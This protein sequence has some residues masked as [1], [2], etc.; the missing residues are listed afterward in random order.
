MVK[1]IS[2]PHAAWKPKLNEKERESSW[3]KAA[4]KNKSLKQHANARMRFTRNANEHEAEAKNGVGLTTKDIAVLQNKQYRLSKQ[5]AHCHA[6]RGKQENRAKNKANNRA[7]SEKPG[8]RTKQNTKQKA[9]AKAKADSLQAE[10]AA[11]YKAN[12]TGRTTDFGLGDET[13]AD[14]LKELVHGIM[15]S[16]AGVFQFEGE[17]TTRNWIRDHGEKSREEILS[18][19]EWAAYFL[20]TK[21]KI[22]PGKEIK[23]PET[24][25][26]MCNYVRN[27]L[28]RIDTFDNGNQRDFRRFTGKEAKTVVLTYLLAK[29]VSGYD[30]TS[31]EGSLQRYIEKEMGM[32]HGFCLRKKAGAGP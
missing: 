2:K 14:E 18:S 31:L 24:M 30:A 29:C 11:E 4:G 22:T 7:R 28:M 6:W 21:Q 26:F 17:A 32:P 15:H 5:L 12:G 27:P 9:V 25:D 10:R 23:C 16:S 8:N 3:K 1:T 20:V 13:R 19:G